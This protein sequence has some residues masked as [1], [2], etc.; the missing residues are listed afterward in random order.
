[1]HHSA[2]ETG[3]SLE[4]S[5]LNERTVLQQQGTVAISLIGVDWD[6]GDESGRRARAGRDILSLC[7]S[8]LEPPIPIH[9]VSPDPSRLT[10]E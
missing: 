3:Y 6:R 7:L 5:I 1:M 10:V 9:P 2:T 4:I 8:R